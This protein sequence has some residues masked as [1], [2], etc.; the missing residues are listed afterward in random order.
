MVALLPR[1]E[2]LLVRKRLRSLQYVE[3]HEDAPELTLVFGAEY[4][5]TY[6][7]VKL[8][9]PVS[10]LAGSLAGETGQMFVVAIR[11]KEGLE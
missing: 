10:G 5:G 1:P 2:P 11:R 3:H 9:G 7:T 4:D 8:E 6:I